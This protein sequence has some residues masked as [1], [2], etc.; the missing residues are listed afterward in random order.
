M[1]TWE[2]IEKRMLAHIDQQRAIIQAEL[3]EVRE[4][5]ETL[6]QRVASEGYAT[7]QEARESIDEAFGSLEALAEDARRRERLEML[8]EARKAMR[9]S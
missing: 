7:R 6:S 9:A 8:A 1:A 2:Q 4:Q 5:I 3:S